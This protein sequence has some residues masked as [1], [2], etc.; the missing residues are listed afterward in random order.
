MWRLI[1][2]ETVSIKDF[3]GKAVPSKTCLQIIKFFYQ[4]IDIFIGFC[5][6][7][8][9]FYRLLHHMVQNSRFL[10]VNYKAFAMW[11]VVFYL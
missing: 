9:K 8:Y 5:L 4:N 3:L 6:A 10:N 7:K 11:P 2:V 1:G